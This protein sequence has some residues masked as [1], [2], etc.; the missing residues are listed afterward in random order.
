M[1]RI[2]AWDEYQKTARQVIAEGCVLLKNDH[3]VLPLQKDA[4]VAIFGRIQSSY[5]K[6]GTGSGGMVNVSKV[7]NIV[8]G[9]ELS[10]HVQV[11]QDLKQIYAD[12]E[13]DHPYDEGLGWGQE[14]WSQDEMPLS[15]EVVKAVA[16][17][18]DVAIAIIGR[19]AG[20]DRDASETKGS[21]MLTDE[22]T[23][24]LAKVRQHFAKVIVLLN[25]GG[26]IDMEFVDTC[27][28]DAVLYVW[29][30]GMCGGLGTADVLIGAANPSGKMTDTIAYQIADYPSNAYFGNKVANQYC[31]DI[32]V[33]YRYFETF[34]KDKVRYPFGYGLSYTQFTFSDEK[35]CVDMEKQQLIVELAV[36]NCGTVAGKEVAQVY[37]S[38]PQGKLGKAARELVA[39]Q[40]TD[41]L[42]PNASQTLK[43]VADF[44]QFAAYDDGGVTGHKSAFVLEAG[45]YKVYAG[46][47]VRAAKE[48]GSFTLD[49]L[50]MMRQ[51][52]EAMAPIEAF[53][54]MHA[55]EQNGEVVCVFEPVPM[56]TVTMAERCLSRLPQE[57]DPATCKVKNA[58]DKDDVFILQDVKEGRASLADFVAQFSDDDLT[59]IVRGEG[60]GS[61]LVTP[62]TASALG[63][64]SKRLREIYKIP[65]VCCD[66]GPSGMRLDCGIKAFSLPNGLMVAS[67]C[68]PELITQ[69]Y[70]FTGLEMTNN[71]VD[72]LLGPGMNI[73]RHP[74]NGRNFEYFSEDPFVTGLFGTAM[75]KG[76]SDAGAS[77]TVKHF[78]A[79]NQEYNRRDHNSMIS[80]RAIREIYL[81]GFEMTVQSGYAKSIM[82][83]YGMV[84]GIFTAGNYDLNTTILRKEWG[85]T[86]IVMTDWW[87]DINELG[88]P[89]DKT[90]FA[91]MVRSQNDLYM[92][93]PDGN[94]NAS[95]DNTLEALQTGK[96]T[97][98][99]L[100]RTAM[101]VCRFVLD[102]EAMRRSMGC[103]TKVE[104]INRPTDDMDLQLDQ[105]ES[106][107]LDGDMT[108][109]LSGQE[110]KANT[111]FVLAL[112]VQKLGTYEVTV[113]ASSDLDELAQLPCTFCIQSIP[114]LSFT[115]HGMNGG[116]DSIGKELVLRQRFCIS[117]LLVGS[118]GLKVK[119]IS[120][121]Y[122]NDDTT[123][124][125]GF[126]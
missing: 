34:A 74:L 89:K 58:A 90:N 59:C 6:S 29:Q 9:L 45:E 30:G 49:E 25:V 76:L 3:Q 65:A 118:N 61:I 64:V 36:A 53:D 63:G 71:R 26:V 105:V 13:V 81:K 100:Q 94:T 122:L 123:P 125:Y 12:W 66:D 37:I 11:D 40:K 126:D 101:N 10:K 33:G 43:L 57:I 95:G 106:I 42:A 114:V 112:D 56:A 28:P 78:C 92:V 24:M 102:T 19:T 108:I 80:E 4:K 23:N 120:F 47:D 77:G 32:F 87:A 41:E 103:P 109:D 39:L 55:V 88:K 16:D 15:D 84:N 38:A 85:Y 62:G 48:V 72:N 82:T 46:S 107:V 73:H 93:C 35:V 86:G 1:K 70:T 116:E 96:I 68:N 54:R 67:S 115:F 79:N 5:Y 8:E 119:D 7:Y 97:K 75:L 21:Y 17:R 91:A 113:R 124:R 99:E 51:C 117:R 22:E 69:L 111:N 27:Q 104:T 60:M 14:R 121:K 2:L 110:C 98:A 50:L 31:E 52:E 20:E 83:T 44:M 18:N